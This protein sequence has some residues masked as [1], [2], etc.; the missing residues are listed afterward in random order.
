MVGGGLTSG[1][2]GEAGFE[3][4][5]FGIAAVVAGFGDERCGESGLGFGLG[6]GFGGGLERRRHDE[7]EAG[8]FQREVREVHAHLTAGDVGDLVEVGADGLD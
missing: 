4:G 6:E 8:A 5:D 7:G 3:G 2:G 1:H